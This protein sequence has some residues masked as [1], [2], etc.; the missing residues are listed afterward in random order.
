MADSPLRYH[1]RR[2]RR[3]GAGRSDC[4]IGTIEQS[5]FIGPATGPVLFQS[6]KHAIHQSIYDTEVEN[7]S[8]AMTF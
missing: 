5:L 2:G 8:N 1:H 6:E 3:L 4:I 7:N